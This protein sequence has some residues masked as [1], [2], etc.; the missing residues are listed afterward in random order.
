MMLNLSPWS[1][2]GDDPIYKGRTCFYTEPEIQSDAQPILSPTYE[3]VRFQDAIDEE[4]NGFPQLKKK[5]EYVSGEI[6]RFELLLLVEQT[7]GT[8]DAK[9]ASLL[10]KM[11][12]KQSDPDQS[13]PDQ[14]SHD[15]TYND[16]MYGKKADLD[17]ESLSRCY[18]EA[19]S[20]VHLSENPNLRTGEFPRYCLIRKIQ[21]L[22]I[23]REEMTMSLFLGSSLSPNE[24][25]LQI[26]DADED[27]PYRST[28]RYLNYIKM[29]KAMARPFKAYVATVD[30]WQAIMLI[31]LCPSYTPDKY[32]TRH[33]RAVADALLGECASSSQDSDEAGA[34]AFEGQKRA[35]FG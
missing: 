5:L 10:H 22:K 23:Q 33:V 9:K 16:L 2:E 18:E 34:S 15:Y 30:A 7:S 14:D 31:E 29:R 21:E 32:E 25:L 1:G 28:P 4:N 8:T 12:H 13:D 20:S 24:P 35:R 6:N 17:Q 26:A 27:A 3:A 19:M 11:S